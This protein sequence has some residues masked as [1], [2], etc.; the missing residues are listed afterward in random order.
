M[1]GKVDTKTPAQD[2]RFIGG[3]GKMYEK[4]I[5]KA[6]QGCLSFCPFL[7]LFQE[8]PGY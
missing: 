6:T 1:G 4:I 3:Y 7:R 2:D 8:K 5:G